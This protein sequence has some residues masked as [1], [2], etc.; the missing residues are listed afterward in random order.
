MF[1]IE[2]GGAWFFFVLFFHK[3]E[4]WAAAQWL[5]LGPDPCKGLHFKKG[6]LK[7]TSFFDFSIFSY[8]SYFNCFYMISL[9]F[10]VLLILTTFHLFS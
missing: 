2:S 8:F 10:T 5:A 1:T 6:S 4:H 3:K 7:W 9:Y